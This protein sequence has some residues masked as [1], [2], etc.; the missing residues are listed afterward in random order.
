MPTI[1][2]SPDATKANPGDGGDGFAL[3]RRAVLASATAAAGAAASVTLA[4][5]EITPAAGG[6]GAPLVELHFPAGTLTV[7]QKAAMI[8]GVTDVLV[9]A[10][11]IPAVQTNNLW[12]Q[13]F[14]T[15]EGG[16]G[17]GG[18]VFVPRPK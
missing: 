17:F 6:Y 16:W 12:V 13:I 4:A 8:K 2:R 7:E 5:A 15:A 9:E 3:S 1:D 11:K 18:K 10:A 14:E